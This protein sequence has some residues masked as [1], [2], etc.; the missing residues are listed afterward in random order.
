MS[1]SFGATRGPGATRRPG[2]TLVELMVALS[3]FSILMVGTMSFYKRQGSAFT[4]GNSRMTVMQN[5]R[6]GI[7]ALEQNL[8]TAGVGVPSKQPVLVYA[9]RDVIAFNADYA[10]NIANDVF[11]V[12]Y[13][14]R[15]PNG[16]V[17]A[18]TPS[19]KITLPRT[20]F[21]YPDASYF[22]GS[23][24]SPAETIIFFFEP[25]TTTSRTDDY[26]LY[27]Q[28]N[29]MPPE[30]VAR[31]LLKT[32]R[33][34]F[35]YYVLDET[36]YGSP[37]L[38]V[39]SYYLPGW[40]GIAIHG[41]PGD[42]GLVAGVDSVRAVR[43]T[44]AATNGEP[45]SRESVR[46]ISR[47][48][49]LPNAGVASQPSC[50]GKPLLGTTLIPMGRPSTSTMAGHIELQWARA[51][52]EATGEQ[53]VLRYVIWRRTGSEGPWGDPMA[54][55]SPGASSYVYR[56]FS[57]LPDVGYTYALAA[58]DCTPQYSAMTETVLVS[59]TDA[60]FGSVELE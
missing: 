14:P 53:D 32:G 20:T 48:I 23:G 15:L 5:L 25:D 58:Q 7:N 55:V 17:S 6:Y 1:A 10:T 44:Y 50:G 45:G 52:D 42:T 3:L 43:V 41:S 4:A 60:E 40:H 2:V 34:F 33:D 18:L 54:S 21:A 22:L 9:G 56:D 57:A 11:A 47:L 46:Q 19:R 38:E 24:N 28:V 13:D 27:R 26:V 51:T 12:Y 31:R 59:W 16:G 37:V 29:D 35:T 36:L 49:R 8:R 39:P 30:T